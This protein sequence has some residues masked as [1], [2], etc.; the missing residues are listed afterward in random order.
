[1]TTPAQTSTAP[2]YLPHLE[3]LRAVAAVG[4]L[5]TH[6]AFQTGL[7]PAS[8]GGA[9]LARFDY[10]VAVFFSL[11]AFLLWR[12]FRGQG[13]YMRRC[14][15]IL[16][17]Y[18]VCVVTVLLLLPEAF[19]TPGYVGV[20]TLTFTQIYLPQAL[21]GGLTHLWSLCV[22]VA[23]YVVLPLIAL[24]VRG[25]SQGFRCGFFGALAIT[26]WCWALVPWP[27]PGINFQ[28]FPISYLPWFA[29]GLLAAEWEGRISMPDWV[30]FLT[31][32]LAIVVCWVAGQAWYGPQGLVHPSPVEFF[33][34]TIAGTIFAALVLLPYAW[35][36]GR[37][38][39]SARPVVLVGTWSYS[40]FLWHMAVLSIVF[41]VLGVPVFSGQFILVAVGTM[42]VSIPVAA[43]SYYLIEKPGV[44][45]VK[46]VWDSRW[47]RLGGSA[48]SRNQSVVNQ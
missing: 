14:A 34:R 35:G 15:R 42:A 32:P 29:V 31:W 48:Q 38:I 40:L 39:L 19:G 2:R 46:S 17:A 43:A 24:V 45:W 16:P 26:G 21:A 11:S 7:D 8:V 47:N 13:Y 4:V 23:F 30:R 25:K 36:S 22:E 9:I 5:L 28:I 10:F 37:S 44:G 33:F 6:V 3:G 41:P 18:V 1:M 12:N 20:A 27:E